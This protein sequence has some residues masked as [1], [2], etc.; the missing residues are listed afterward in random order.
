[1][2]CIEQGIGEMTVLDISGHALAVSKARL[3]ERA[4]GVTR[5]DVDVTQARFPAANFTTSCLWQGGHEF[6]SSG[7]SNLC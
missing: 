6:R 3:G 2:T 7:V 1:M 4:K 5:M